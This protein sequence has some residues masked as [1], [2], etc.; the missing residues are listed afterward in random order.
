[1]KATNAPDELEPK[2]NECQAD[3]QNNMIAFP[4]AGKWEVWAPGTVAVAVGEK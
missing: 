1:M 3:T 4:K 2:H